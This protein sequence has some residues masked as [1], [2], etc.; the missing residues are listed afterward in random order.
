MSPNHPAILR[1]RQVEL[2]TGLSRTG[3]YSKL[4]PKSRY[5]DPSFPRQISLGGAVV[6]WIEAEVEAWIEARIGLRDG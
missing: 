5:Y 2:R 6:G 1:R 3:I 4:N